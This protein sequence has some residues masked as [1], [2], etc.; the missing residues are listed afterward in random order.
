MLKET[1]EYEDYNGEKR[2]EDFY[3][4][5]NKAE[6]IEMNLSIDGGLEEYIKGIIA[7]RDIPTISALFKKIVL[8]AYGE[9]T[10][11]GKRFIKSEELSKA[12]TE[13]E[14]YSELFVKLVTDEE[15]MAAF[16]N[17]IVPKV[18]RPASP[19]PLNK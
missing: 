10:P 13:T 7:A 11:D 17:G 14:A 2:K 19:I 6:I 1:I 12:F 16:I 8:K 18:E 3:F 9:K 15:K 4:N 5:L